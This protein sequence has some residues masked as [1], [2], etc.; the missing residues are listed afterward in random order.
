MMH[1]VN[2]YAW[3]ICAEHPKH[4]VA[5]HRLGGTQPLVPAQTQALQLDTQ[6]PSCE[7]TAMPPP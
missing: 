4:G 2:G 3:Q 7:R 1:G 5:T 6:V